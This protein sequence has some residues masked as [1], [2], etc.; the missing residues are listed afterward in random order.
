M[1]QAGRVNRLAEKNRHQRTIKKSGLKFET[2]VSFISSH[3]G[4]LLQRVL[5][6]SRLL[7]AVHKWMSNWHSL[8]IQRTVADDPAADLSWLDKAVGKV[9]FFSVGLHDLTGSHWCAAESRVSRMRPLTV[10]FNSAEPAVA[11]QMCL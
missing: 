7:G 2:A 10:M 5:E 9:S 3:A 1:T 8:I 11:L 4:L 6:R